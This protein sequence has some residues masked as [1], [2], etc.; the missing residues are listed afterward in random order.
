MPKTARPPMHPGERLRE[1]ILPVLDIPIPEVAL[2][3]GVSEPSLRAIVEER[4]SVTVEMAH[5]LARLFNNDAEMWL[6]LQA[7]CDL[8]AAQRDLAD[9]LARIEAI[10]AA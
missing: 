1:V 9:E 6:G 4:D 7:D 2:R 3:L 8:A 10:K 5:R